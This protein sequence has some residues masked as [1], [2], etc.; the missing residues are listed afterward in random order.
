MA[1]PDFKVKMKEN[2]KPKKYKHF[3]KGSKIG[4]TL[5]TR[6]RLERS[7]LN[8]HTFSIGQSESAEC[9]CHFKNE[10]SL[11]YLID[12]F[13]YTSER[14]ILFDWVEHYIP[15]FKSLGKSHKYDILV[16]GINIDDPDFHYTN[17]SLSIAVQNFIFKT[18]RFQI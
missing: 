4:N 3:N 1:L 18:K 15:K 6:I 9:C 14:Q 17:T 10:S 11:H 2:I 12:C 8:L 7:E 5:L 13:L 16:K